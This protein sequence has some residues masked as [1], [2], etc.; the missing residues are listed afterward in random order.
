MALLSVRDLTVQF[1]GLRAVDRF[2][3]DVEQ[4]R[5]H[6]LIGPN[7]AGKTSVINVITGLYPATGS[8]RLEGEELLGRR[9]HQI[10]ALG[11]TRTFQNVELFSE[12]TVLEN[13][14]VGAHR[15]LPYG[16]LEATVRAGRRWRQERA[17]TERAE[18]ILRTLGVA[19]DRRREARGLPFAKQRRLE[20]A[21]ALASGPRLV[22]LDETAAGMTVAEVAELNTILL[23][24]KERQGLTILLVDH[25]MQVVMRI[26]DCITVLHFGQKIAE[27]VTESV[28]S[29]PEVIRAYLG[30]RRLRAR[31]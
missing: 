16:V 4:G 5:I 26:S 3:L 8:V 24:L 28:R 15:R 14:L 6:S 17:E 9:P 20:L 1:G 10:A 31:R 11:V 25:V 19:D 12:M 29:N 22:L 21:R 13:V 27:G 30:E 18:E 2:S 23:E 7:G